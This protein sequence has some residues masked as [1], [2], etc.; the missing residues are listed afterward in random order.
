MFVA[1]VTSASFNVRSVGSPL[2]EGSS[3]VNDP[4]YCNDSAWDCTVPRPDTARGP[5]NKPALTHPIVIGAP[6]SIR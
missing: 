6:G 5:L 2:E 4:C 1:G 3:S